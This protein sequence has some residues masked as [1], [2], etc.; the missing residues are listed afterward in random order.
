MITKS[1]KLGVIV[2]VTK[3]IFSL[4]P[5]ERNSFLYNFPLYWLSRQRLQSKC[6]YAKEDRRLNQFSQPK[7]NERVSQKKHSKQ[8]V[9]DQKHICLFILCCHLSY[10]TVF[11]LISSNENIVPF[12]VTLFHFVFPFSVSIHFE[13]K[14]IGEQMEI[15]KKNLQTMLHSFCFAAKPYKNKNKNKVQRI[16]KSVNWRSN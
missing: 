6:L 8:R 12:N 4:F 7:V 3:F 2:T 10:Y 1:F 16:N 5:P 14:L 9:K 15:N 11:C 13:V